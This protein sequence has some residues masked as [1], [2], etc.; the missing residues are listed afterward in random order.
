LLEGITGGAM[1]NIY[2]IGDHK[3]TYQ[4]MRNGENFK[5]PVPYPMFFVEEDSGDCCSRDCWCRCCCNPK[6]P[7]LLKFYH[8]SPPVDPGPLMCCGNSCG[9]QEDETHA[10]HEHGAFLTLERL[11]LCQRLPNC[12]VCMECCQDEIRLH[13][14][15]VGSANSTPGPMPGDIPTDKLLMRGVVPIG[16]GGCTPTVE[17][18]EK[19]PGQASDNNIGFAEN[20]VMVVEGQTCFGGCYDLCF[21]TAFQISSQRGKSADIGEIKK[22]KPKCTCEECCRACCSTAD[23]YDMTLTEKGTA[24]NPLH[25]AM[26]VGEMVHMDYMFFEHDENY[27]TVRR[28]G[29]GTMIYILLCLCYCYGCLCPIKCCLYIPDKKN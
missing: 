15:D 27:C 9:D 12:W 10:M 17:V 2:I 6:H 4:Q 18:F 28:E 7:S 22:R 5:D 8:A 14:G 25:K 13:A 20:Q 26:L 1:P 24:M 29:D 19:V 21:D 23:T 11:G 3:R 16:G